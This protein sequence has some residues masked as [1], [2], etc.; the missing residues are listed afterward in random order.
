M[1]GYNL[2]NLPPNERRLVALEVKAAYLIHCANKDSRDASV[3]AKFKR[4]RVTK[5]YIQGEIDKLQ[6]DERESFRGYLN[7]YNA[8]SKRNGKQKKKV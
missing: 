6:G 2:G 3:S 7:K 1:L 4:K 5:A 8:M